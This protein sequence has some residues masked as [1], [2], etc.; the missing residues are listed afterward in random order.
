MRFLITGAA[1]SFQSVDACIV[2]DMWESKGRGAI[3]GVYYL[4]NLGMGLVLPLL[5][6]VLDRYM[7]LERGVLDP[8]AVSVCV[9]AS[10]SAFSASLDLG[11]DKER[12]VSFL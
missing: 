8:R 3:M 2:A 7:G 11:G 12:R 4:S 5:G 10:Y 1:S 6:G 9:L